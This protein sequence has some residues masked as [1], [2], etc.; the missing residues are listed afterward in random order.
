MKQCIQMQILMR[1]KQNLKK[2][3]IDA[4]LVSDFTSIEK[5]QNISII[6]K[7]CDSDFDISFDLSSQNIPSQ[8]ELNF[9]KNLRQIEGPNIQL[10]QIQNQHTSLKTTFNNFKQ[11]INA[12]MSNARQSQMQFSANLV[13]LFQLNQFGFE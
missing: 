9:A 3:N 4:N 7:N 2:L 8:K 6:Q 13:R 10:K 11:E 12:A 1:Q 5:H